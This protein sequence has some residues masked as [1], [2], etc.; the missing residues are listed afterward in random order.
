MSSSAAALQIR[1]FGLNVQNVSLFSTPFDR[2][3]TDTA[4]IR[5]PAVLC[6]RVEGGPVVKGP[7]RAPVYLD[8]CGESL[9]VPV[10][11]A[12]VYLPTHEGVTAIGPREGPPMKRVICFE[13]S[14]IGLVAS[15]L[16]GEIG[17]DASR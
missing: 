10:H 11:Y 9:L 12:R 5:T 8:T 7:F 15:G 14:F 4:Q 2:S 16:Q 6:C 3:E 13:W 17:T 1:P